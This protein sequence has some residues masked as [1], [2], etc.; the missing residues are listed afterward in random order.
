VRVILLIDNYDSFVYNLYQ[1]LQE[2]GAQVQV[3][4]ND[5]VDLQDIEEMA[6][7]AIV[8]SPGPGYPK[9]A[10]VSCGAVR[11]FGPRIPVLGVCLGHQCIGAAFGAT[12]DRAGEVMHGKSSWIHHDGKGVLS[13]LPDPLEA[14]R[15]HSL[16]VMREGL[17]DCLEVSAWTDRGI[18]MGLRHRR[19]PIEGVQ[20]HPE[21]IMTRDGKALLGNFLDGVRRYGG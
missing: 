16:A 17:P 8:V 1:Y 11:H 4:R 2:L 12:V 5:S 7:E 18:I 6:P 3:A 19:H 13:G 21:S 10:G 14:I 15:Y 20:F 9:D